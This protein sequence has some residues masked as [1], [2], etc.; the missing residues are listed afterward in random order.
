PRRAAAQTLTPPKRLIIF[1]TD[2]G[3]VV[4]D[5]VHGDLWSPGS[6]SRPLLTNAAASSPN[7]LP[8]SPMLAPMAPIVNEI[9]T[10][11]GVDNLV[12]LAC[13]SG[14]RASDGH[15]CPMTTTLTCTLPKDG[16][17]ARAA[18]I[19]YVAG[20]RLRANAAMQPSIVFWGDSGT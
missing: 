9:V 1:Y 7:T 5:G 12:R 4:G 10:L 2:H 11:D 15:A 8:P 19:D 3:R 14:M 20:L 18:S 13:T 6:T 16:P 17:I